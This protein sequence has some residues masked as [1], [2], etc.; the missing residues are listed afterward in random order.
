MQPAQNFIRYLWLFCCFYCFSTALPALERSWPP[1]FVLSAEHQEQAF[2]GVIYQR[3][4]FIA[5][6]LMSVHL[7][8]VD[9]ATPGLRFA[10]CAVTTDAPRVVKLTSVR[11]CATEQQAQIA[12]NAGFF[13]NSLTAQWRGEG[14]L[15][16]LSVR[17]GELLSPWS[18][19]AQFHHGVNISEDNQVIFIEADTKDRERLNSQPKVNYYNAIAGGVRLLKQGQRVATSQNIHPQTAIGL[20]QE[21]NQQQELLLLVVDGRQPGFSEGIS[22]VELAHLM[23]SLGAVEALALDGGG[24]STLLMQD[25]EGKL[26]L[27]NRPSDGWERLI[28]D[29]L[30]LFVPALE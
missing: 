2:A 10:V 11:Q 17:K 20:V 27:Q 28:G 9:L 5:P 8:R 15:Q 22:Y 26:L 3:L 18:K 12:V 7:L 23:Q 16:S 24:S 6:R 30:L 1:G 21:K 29:S 4:L 19:G 13:D 25:K 14:A